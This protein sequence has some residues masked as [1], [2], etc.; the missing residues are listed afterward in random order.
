MKILV[1]LLAGGL[2]TWRL[3]NMLVN[4][5]GPFGVFMRL[6]ELAGIEHDSAGV[7][8]V[9]PVNNVLSCIWCTSVWV[10]LPMLLLPKR[11][12]HALAISTIAIIVAERGVKA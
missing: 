7:P 10:A 6:R 4:E 1:D 9:Q 2:A 5:Y 3:S 11:V 8:N 12:S